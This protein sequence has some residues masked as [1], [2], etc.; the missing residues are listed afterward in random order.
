MNTFCKALCFG[1]QLLTGFSGQATNFNLDQNGNLWIPN[2]EGY[3]FRYTW[4][5]LP[6]PLW[7]D[8]ERA[9]CVRLYNHNGEGNEQPTDQFGRYRD[10]RAIRVD[11]RIWLNN[12]ILDQ[13]VVIPEWF[14]G[15]SPEW[16]IPFSQENQDKPL[17]FFFGDTHGCWQSYSLIRRALEAVLLVHPQ[18]VHVVITGDLAD[19]FGLWNE[20]EEEAPDRLGSETCISFLVAL[21]DALTEADEE[22]SL[23]IMLGNH[24]TQT[25]EDFEL[26]R[27]AFTMKGF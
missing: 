19:R 8:D 3:G 17:I 25:T 13:L 26:F 10:E 27:G 22:N 16:I 7:C 6:L 18:N 9:L 24:D 14:Q 21:R 4:R 2:S 12:G 15:A 23:S 1:L 11:L 20:G 5:V